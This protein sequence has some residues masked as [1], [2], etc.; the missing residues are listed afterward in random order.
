MFTGILLSYIYFPPQWL[1]SY[2]P[3]EESAVALNEPAKTLQESRFR[4]ETMQDTK[5]TEKR[6][7]GQ[8]NASV[9]DLKRYLG[10]V[11]VIY[12]LD[13]QKMYEVINCESGWRPEASNR[14][15][16]GIAQFT[17]P[18]WQWMNEMRGMN[19]DYTNAYFQLEMMG[20]AWNRGL[21]RHWDC[22]RM[23]FDHEK[24]A[25]SLS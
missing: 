24:L 6:P 4:A 16:F 11:A 23:M 20:W 13:Y 25:P 19:A 18:T 2:I 17:R 14:V 15:S 22:Y 5:P 10:D 7:S 9:N 3:I 8:N 21:E 12:G 1:K